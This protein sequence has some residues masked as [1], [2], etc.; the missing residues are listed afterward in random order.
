MTSMVPAC[1]VSTGIVQE[2]TIGNLTGTTILSMWD[3]NIDKLEESKAYDF[4]KVY[5]KTYEDEKTITFSSKSFFNI[6][7]SNT[8]VLPTQDE[9]CMSRSVD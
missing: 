7:E 2:V 6:T 8:D 4:K 1:A 5:V 3:V 9:D